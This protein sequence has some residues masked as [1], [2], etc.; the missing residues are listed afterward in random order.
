ME[1]IKLDEAKLQKMTEKYAIEGAEKAIR[2]FYTGYN[3]PFMKQVL[4]Q[5][6]ESMPDNLHFDMPTMTAAIN[7]AISE[8]VTEMANTVV[9]NTFLPMLNRLFSQ[10]RK[11]VVTTADIFNRFGDTMRDGLGDEFDR[12]LLELQFGKKSGTFYNYITLYFLY[13]G[14]EKYTLN[15]ISDG[16]KNGCEQSDKFYK[17]T[18]LPGYSHYNPSYYPAVRLMKIRMDGATLE[19]PFTPDMLRDEFMRYVAGLLLNNT[20]VTIARYHEYREE[21]E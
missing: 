18:E 5:L 10:E 7:K 13:G 6:E 11:S 21:E 2:E 19:M 15:I 9:A 4:K 8:K 14:E 1:A 17:I 3:S 20:K 12:E 16:P